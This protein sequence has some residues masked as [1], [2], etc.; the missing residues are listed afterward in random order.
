MHAPGSL[1]NRPWQCGQR[2]VAVQASPTSTAPWQLLL[3]LQRGRNMRMQQQQQ[4]QQQTQGGV[5]GRAGSTG[6]RVTGRCYS[7]VLAAAVRGCKLWISSYLASRL[8]Q[9]LWLQ[10]QR[11]AVAAAVLVAAGLVPGGLPS[12]ASRQQTL[13]QQQLRTAPLQQQQVP[14]RQ[15]PSHQCHPTPVLLVQLQLNL[16][17]LAL[18]LLWSRV[19][20]QQGQQRHLP[21]PPCHHPCS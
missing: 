1:L 5:S 17:S 8:L 6:I 3:A 9:W 10:L 16:R 18:A 7:L 4:R 13:L 14:L 19:Q 20:A 15:H 11:A 2:G 12:Q 21:L